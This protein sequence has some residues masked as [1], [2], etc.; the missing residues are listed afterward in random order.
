MTPEKL[1]ER[2]RQ[3]EE[4]VKNL[5]STE[6]EAMDEELRDLER[7]LG[8]RND[9][10]HDDEEPGALVPAPTL[11]RTPVLAGGNARRLEEA[12]EE[13]ES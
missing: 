13:L 2:I 1:D 8:L 5:S 4:A 11:P 10:G 6:R 7:Q 12:I 3:L 9:Q